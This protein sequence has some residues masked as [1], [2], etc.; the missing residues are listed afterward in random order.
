VTYTLSDA[1][2]EAI[3]VRAVCAGFT[4]QSANDHS[5]LRERDP[6]TASRVARWILDDVRGGWREP[7]DRP[8]DPSEPT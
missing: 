8:G 4:A 2:L 6:L 1:E 7:G 3:V 5:P